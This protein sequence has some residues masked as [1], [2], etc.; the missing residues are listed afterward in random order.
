MKSINIFFLFSFLLLYCK[1]NDNAINKI[2]LSSYPVELQNYVSGD[3]NLTNDKFSKLEVKHPKIKRK[4]KYPNGEITKKEFIDSSKYLVV[5]KVF[6][7]D[8]SI[9]LKKE[10][11]IYLLNEDYSL[12]YKIDFYDEK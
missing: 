11:F 1:E 2:L 9:F 6:N 12:V 4:I 7:L 10:S 3:L 8:D 5:A